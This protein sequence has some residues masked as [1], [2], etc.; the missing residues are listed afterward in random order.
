M[1]VLYSE[2]QICFYTPL[3]IQAQVQK[4]NCGLEKA[5]PE[6]NK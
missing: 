2:R 1:S 6:E 4:T 5:V 3:L